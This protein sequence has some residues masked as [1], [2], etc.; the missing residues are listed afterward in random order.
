MN[1]YKVIGTRLVWYEAFIRAESEDEAEEIAL[2]GQADV[3]W[4]ECGVGAFEVENI[5]EVSHD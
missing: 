1:T 2:E 5:D 4:K 3:E